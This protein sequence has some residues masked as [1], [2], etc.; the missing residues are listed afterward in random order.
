MIVVNVLF[1]SGAHLDAIVFVLM[2][3][4]SALHVRVVNGRCSSMGQS[5]PFLNIYKIIERACSSRRFTTSQ[6]KESHLHPGR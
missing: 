5:P 3:R 4:G 1:I 6:T 2:L